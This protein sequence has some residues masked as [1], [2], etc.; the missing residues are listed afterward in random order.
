[1]PAEELVAAQAQAVERLKVL[2]TAITD[3]PETVLE[4][5]GRLEIPYSK[6]EMAQEW[7]GD[8]VG[9]E[10]ICFRVSDLEAGEAR[11]TSLA[12][13]LYPHLAAGQAAMHAPDPNLLPDQNLTPEA[14][15]IV[16]KLRSV[17][18]QIDAQMQTGEAQ[19]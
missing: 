3:K 5:L 6:G 4:M 15:N 12:S 9:T 18:S 8:P 11:N 17:G 14:K 13:R 10:Y 1:M 2:M 7:D 16:A 19:V